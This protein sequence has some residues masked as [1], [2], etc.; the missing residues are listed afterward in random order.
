MLFTSKYKNI[1]I[2]FKLK[3]FDSSIC[4]FQYHEY[5]NNINIEKYIS[6]PN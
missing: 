1:S 6:Y 4:I 2:H 3:M 5:K